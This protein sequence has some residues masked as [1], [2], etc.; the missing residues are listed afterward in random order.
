MDAKNFVIKPETYADKSGMKTELNINSRAAYNFSKR[1][2]DEFSKAI[3]VLEV[4]S[5]QFRVSDLGI[6]HRDYLLEMLNDISE[7][8]NNQVQQAKNIL[9]ENGITD[10][11]T[12][13]NPPRIEVMV[14]SPTD[15]K[16]IQLIYAFDELCVLGDTLRITDSAKPAEVLKTLENINKKMVDLIYKA[17]R[18]AKFVI[19]RHVENINKIRNEQ[20]KKKQAANKETGGAKEAQNGDKGEKGTKTEDASVEGGSS[21]PSDGSGFQEINE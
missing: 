1:Y 4:K 21:E 7:E 9:D 13:A 2:F 18:F 17:E 15:H 3:F 8:I 11:A 19:I 16:L 5:E 10:R 14:S 12:Y 6:Q 20:K